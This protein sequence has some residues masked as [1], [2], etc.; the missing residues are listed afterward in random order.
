M[1]ARGSCISRKKCL[2]LFQSGKNLVTLR[3]FCHFP[4]TK[5]SKSVT[6]GPQVECLHLSDKSKLGSSK[7]ISD[8]HS[9]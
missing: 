1:I 4:P 5:I 3:E 8:F 7:S 2:D 6:F 9:T